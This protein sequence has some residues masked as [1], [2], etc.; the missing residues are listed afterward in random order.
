MPALLV[1]AVQVVPRSRSRTVTVAF[2]MAA[3]SGS[4]TVPV[5]APEACWAEAGNAVAKVRQVAAAANSNV[6]LSIAAD[7]SLLYLTN[8]GGLPGLQEC[9]MADNC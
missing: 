9:F 1:F 2:G 4:R 6:R 3:S 7:M 5:I 8:I